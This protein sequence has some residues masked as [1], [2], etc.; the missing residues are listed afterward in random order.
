MPDTTTKQRP[1]LSA[2]MQDALLLVLIYDGV[3]PEQY[4]SLMKTWQ[5]ELAELTEVSA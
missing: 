2:E 3:T 1:H 4:G 5:D